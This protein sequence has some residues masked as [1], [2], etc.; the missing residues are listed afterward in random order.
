MKGIAIFIPTLNGG[1]AEKMMVHLANEFASNGYQVD[2]LVGNAKG[3]YLEM[4][5]KKVSIINF[6]CSRMY[7]TLPKLIR[8]LISSKP[9]V[10]LSALNHTN[11]ISLI[12]KSILRG[13]T[14]HIVS[15]RS[16]TSNIPMKKSV[17]YFFTKLN[18]SADGIIAISNAVKKDLIQNYSLNPN[19]IEVIYNPVITDAI[20]DQIDLECTNQEL[21]I[22]EGTK[23][24]MS[25]GR[26]SPVKDYPTLIKA[27][28]EASKKRSLKLLIF[29]EGSQKNEIKELIEDY[30]LN[31][32]VMLMGFEKNVMSYYKYADLFILPSLSEGFGN[33]II[34]AMGAGVNVIC[35]KN[36]GSPE[37]LLNNEEFGFLFE[38]SNAESL[39]NVILY[40]L[41]NKKNQTMLQEYSSHFHVK[42]IAQH[43]LKSFTK[44]KI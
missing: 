32:S 42:N 24:L 8:Y 14:K 23:L 44:R 18:R 41:D 38:K 3:V 25:A 39:S 16:V 29:G 2:L 35:A 22:P 6:K 17:K 21:N 7:K 12:A 20:Q 34:E 28:Y 10:L 11:L 33:V 26:L 5:D 19:M 9:D 43:Y 30:N 37:E 15:V 40:A 36:S 13:R 4:V 1:G 31:G 27:F